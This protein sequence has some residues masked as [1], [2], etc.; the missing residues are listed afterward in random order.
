MD[1]FERNIQSC[2]NK[3]KNSDHKKELQ[4]YLQIRNTIDKV[5]KSTQENDIYS[6]SKLSI[7]LKDKPFQKATEKDMMNF[8]TWLRNNI[9]HDSASLMEARIKRFYKYLFSKNEYKKGKQIQKTLK[10]P[11]NVMWMSTSTTGNELP[12]E[13]ILTE[14]QIKKMLNTCKD[15]RQ[16]TI[17]VSLIDGGLRASELCSLKV[18][19][20]GFDNQLGAYFIL[21]KKAKGLK[22]GQRKIQLFLIPSSTQYI[23]EYLNHHKF[24]NDADAPF[25]YSDTNLTKK[26]DPKDLFLT[27]EGLWFIVTRIAR[28]SEI[29]DIHPHTCRHVSATY[30][31]MKGFN[32][33]MLRERFGWS[34]SSKMPSYYTHLA[35]KDTSDYIKKILGIKDIEEPEESILQ[36]IICWNCNFE[37]PPTH[38]FCGKCSANLKPKKEEI[39]TTAIETGL[40]VQNMI[41]DKDFMIKMMNV[42]AL[43]WDKHQQEK[44]KN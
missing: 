5:K 4:E 36:P 30:C 16:Q 2:L 27:P 23:R 32:E 15:I 6:L 9:G 10:Y 22:T 19:N 14:K 39:T 17:L 38:K 29:K 37:N 41:K 42:M 40:N 1:K 34:R 7:F 13:S 3:I 20:V 43:E 11:E 18:K 12:L 28:D 8:D 25:I 21:P 31:A 26:R 44:N 24:K 35:G 33:A